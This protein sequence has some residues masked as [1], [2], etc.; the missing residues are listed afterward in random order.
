MVEE[1]D[2]SDVS[3]GSHEVSVFFDD[4][5]V[6]FGEDGLVFDVVAVVEGG[7]FAVGSYDCPAVSL[8]SDDCCHN[9]L[10]G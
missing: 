1:V 2:G 4:F 7:D 6:M 5:G 9:R 8:Y 10:F 3:C